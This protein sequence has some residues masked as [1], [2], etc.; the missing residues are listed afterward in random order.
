MPATCADIEGAIVLYTRDLRRP[1]SWSISEMRHDFRNPGLLVPEIE[2]E[3]EIEI[4]H[5]IQQL[6]MTIINFDCT[7]VTV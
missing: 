5:I 6:K 1:K 4:A 3:I 2:I 7:V